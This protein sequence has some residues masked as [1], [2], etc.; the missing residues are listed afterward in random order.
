MN[1]YFEPHYV[2]VVYE[3]SSDPIKDHAFKLLNNYQNSQIVVKD[4]NEGFEK[5]IPLHGDKRFET[6]IST[7]RKYPGQILR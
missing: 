4:K 7:I 1:L 3:E 2:S 5:G 6:F